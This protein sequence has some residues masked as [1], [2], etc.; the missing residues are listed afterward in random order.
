MLVVASFGF[1]ACG[2]D[3]EAADPAA[4]AQDAQDADADAD[5]GAEGASD[6]GQGAG[7]GNAFGFGGFSSGTVTVTGIDEASYSVSDPALQWNGGGGCNATQFGIVVNANESDTGFTAMQLTAQID[8]DLNGGGTGT[9]DVEGVTL[10][11]VTDGD[12]AAGRPYRGDGTMVIAEHDTGG[13]SSDPN[14]RRM[15]ITIDGTLES[16]TTGVDGT[17]DLVADLVWIMGCP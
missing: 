13:P 16:T 11:L 7:D 4:K 14:A 6:G 1:V 15:A 5:A 17:V 8:A 3:D 12:V 10:L 9:F 2:G